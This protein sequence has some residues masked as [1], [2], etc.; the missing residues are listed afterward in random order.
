MKGGKIS[1]NPAIYT[2]YNAGSLDYLIITLKTPNSERKMVF[3][4]E[5]YMYTY[6]LPMPL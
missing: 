4:K 1:W 3:G 2:P 6:I 5:K